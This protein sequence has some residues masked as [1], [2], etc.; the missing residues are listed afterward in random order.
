MLRRLL[1]LVALAC[2]VAVASPQRAEAHA[3]DVVVKVPP[4]SPQI[5]VEVGF[6]DGTP[7]EAAEVVVTDAAGEEIA[8]GKTDERGVCKLTKP[9]GG[10]YLAMIEAIGHKTH[11]EFEVAA[12]VETTEFTGWRPD[13]T[14]GLVLGVGA[15]LAASF[16]FWWL[17]VRR[18]GTG[19]RS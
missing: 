14:L 18:Q 11:V 1:V 13:R 8:R 5:I 17:R 4:N 7:A 15:L 3:L 16:G 12:A 2:C 10:K 19:D 9:A 6:D